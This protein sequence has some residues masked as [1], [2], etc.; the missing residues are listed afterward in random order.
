[1][2]EIGNWKKWDTVFAFKNNDD[3]ALLPTLISLHHFNDWSN[4][5]EFLW[6]HIKFETSK[7]NNVFWMKF[8]QPK[9]ICNRD[10]QNV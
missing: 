1:M 4:S 10:G 9:V 7:K 5:P 2:L 8:L 6:T 3:S